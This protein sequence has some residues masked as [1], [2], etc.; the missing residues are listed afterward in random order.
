MC[1]CP[2]VPPAVAWLGI[3][4]K[5]A[6]I[7]LW[8]RENQLTQG[9]TLQLLRL[10]GK[11]TLKHICWL[12]S[13]SVQVAVALPHSLSCYGVPDFHFSHILRTRSPPNTSLF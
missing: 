6:E 10:L 12:S 4:V 7:W 3:A 8:W 11:R 2:D 1:L 5:Q 9:F 13:H